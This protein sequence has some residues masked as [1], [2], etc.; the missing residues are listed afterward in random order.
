QSLIDAHVPRLHPPSFPT[1]RASDRRSF[2]VESLRN[3]TRHAWRNERFFDSALL[4]G[5]YLK[6][7][8]VAELLHH[9]IKKL[10]DVGEFQVFA[11]RSEEHTSE[12]QS[13]RDLVCRLLLEKK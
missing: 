7:A 9:V 12:L 3:V 8:D 5:E 4:H 13:R 2:G 6:L 10:G 11:V 1:R